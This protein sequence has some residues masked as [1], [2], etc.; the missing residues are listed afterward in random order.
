MK[1]GNKNVW[2]LGGSSLFNDVGSEM[3]TPLLPFY[4][5]SFGGGGAALG[6]LSGLRE[7]LASLFKLIGGWLSDFLGKRR[8]FVFFGYA[9]SSIFRVLLLI[10]STWKQVVMLISFE[11]FGKIRDAPRDVIIASSVK[12]RGKAFALHQSLDT[13]GGIIGTLIVIFLFWKLALG[14]QSIIIVASL[15]SLFSIL[16][17]FFVKDAKTA[18]IKGKLF[19]GIH[20]LDSRLKYFTFASAVFTLANFGIY[21]FL[22]LKAKELTGSIVIALVLYAVFNLFYAL[23]VVPF[24][25]FSDKVGRKKVLTHGYLLFLLSIIGFIFVTEIYFLFL[26]FAVFGIVYAMIQSNQKS[27]VSDLAGKMKGTALGFYSAVVGIV[28]IPAGLIAG[29][30]WDKNPNM[31]FYYIFV[32][33]VISLV[34]LYFVKEGK[35][36]KR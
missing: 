11:R 32:V 19:E 21:M 13:T 12:K 9:F 1:K 7:G 34:L 27:Y 22:I 28:N 24:G 36:F 8:P 33:G 31:M 2:L 29:L 26:L 10:A 4:V 25:K 18:P 30:L 20:N 6:L 15:I 16:P 5:A 17:L 23:F 3:I 35:E 14:I